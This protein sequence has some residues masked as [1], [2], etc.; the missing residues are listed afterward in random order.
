MHVVQNILKCLVPEN[1]DFDLLAPIL[2]FV[3]K[4]DI[5]IIFE[6]TVLSTLEDSSLYTSFSNDNIGSN[7]N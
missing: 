7:E 6:Y 1:F 4:E 5:N 3:P 2:D